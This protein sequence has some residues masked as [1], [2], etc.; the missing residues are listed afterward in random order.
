MSHQFRVSPVLSRK[1]PK[2]VSM[3]LFFVAPGTN[4]AKLMLWK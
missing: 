4:G 2:V 1:I 3:I